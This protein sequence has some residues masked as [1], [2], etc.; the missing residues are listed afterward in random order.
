[1]FLVVAIAS[2]FWHF[3]S[4]HKY[5]FRKSRSI[6]DF[7]SYAVHVWSSAL[8]SCGES[9]VVSLDISKAFARVWHKGLLAKLPMLGLNQTLIN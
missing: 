9:R 4:N 8:E 6:G 3:L 5:G 2:Y 1:M 7:L